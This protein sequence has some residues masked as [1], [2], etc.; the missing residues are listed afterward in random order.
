ME[1]DVLEVKPAAFNHRFIAY[2][3][4]F[5]PFAAAFLALVAAAAKSP[6][7]ADQLGG[8]RLPL[9]FLGAYIL[10]QT[11]GNMLGGTPGKRMMGLY[12]VRRADGEKPGPGRALARALAHLF[13]Y[14][15]FNLG[16]GVALVHP[17]TRA[18]HDLLAGTVV[19]EPQQKSGAESKLLFAGAIALLVALEG[20]IYAHWVRPPTAAD[21]AAVGKAADALHVMAQIQE[22]YKARHQSYTGDLG[23]LADASGDPKQ[24]RAA[25]GDLFVGE[26][27]RV[28]AGNKAYTITASARDRRRTRLRLDGPP[29][30]VRSE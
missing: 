26:S 29:P 2:V 27:F 16:F 12:V 5:A 17:E 7:L 28:Q 20:A 10:Y 3:I 14:P 1:G 22:E 21:M 15:F 11:V 25:L 8:S 19:V 23:A 24:F 4:D 9:L 6:P 18:L 30:A 13:S